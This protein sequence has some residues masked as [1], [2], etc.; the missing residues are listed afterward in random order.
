[1]VLTI[2]SKAQGDFTNDWLKNKTIETA[3]HSRIYR[4]DARTKR[5]QGLQV[6]G[7]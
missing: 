7:S 3:D 4:L 6:F 2:K 5:L 1:M